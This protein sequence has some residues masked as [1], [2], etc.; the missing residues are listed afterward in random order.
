MECGVLWC[1]VW[2]RYECVDECGVDWGEF[3]RRR[4]GGEVGRRYVE[5]Y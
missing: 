2:L 1:G 4:L 5:S 3:R